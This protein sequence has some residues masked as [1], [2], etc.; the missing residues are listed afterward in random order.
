MEAFLVLGM[1]VALIIGLIS[2]HPLAWVLGGVGLIFGLTG[3]G[4]Q[5]ASIFVMSTFGVMN[6]YTLIAIPLGV[7]T[8]R[9]E[10]SVGFALS[11]A[12]A[13]AYFFFIIMADTFRNNPAAHPTILIWIPN[14]LF[15]ALGSFL[16]WRLSRR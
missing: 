9:K 5:A 12:I 13:F 16:F 8:H 11:L 4:I 6:N 1:F 10:T 2:G 3:W 14:V 7:T 15:L